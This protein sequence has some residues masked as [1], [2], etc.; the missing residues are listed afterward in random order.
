MVRHED[1]AENL[2][3]D[4]SLVVHKKMTKKII[5]LNIS[6]WICLRYIGKCSKYIWR[7]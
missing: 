1:L 2:Q 3:S 7:I 5:S 6:I 4:S